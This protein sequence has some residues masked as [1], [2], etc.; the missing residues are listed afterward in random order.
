[1]NPM[2]E[3]ITKPRAKECSVAITPRTNI[4]TVYFK[5]KHIETKDVVVA[6]DDDFI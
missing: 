2:Q 5:P 6:R 3:M 4:N 1:M